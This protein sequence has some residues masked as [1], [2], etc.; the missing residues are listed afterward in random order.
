MLKNCGIEK[1]QKKRYLSI[2]YIQLTVCSSVI[3]SMSLKFF[4]SDREGFPESGGAYKDC[5]IGQNINI[6]RYKERQTFPFVHSH[7]KSSLSKQNSFLYWS[8]TDEYFKTMYVFVPCASRGI[9]TFVV[10]LD[11]GWGLVLIFS[12]FFCWLIC[13]LSIHTS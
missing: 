1:I 10:F 4:Y 7:V 2:I 11:G 3:G 6:A 9:C 12:S 8:M 5:M 13:S